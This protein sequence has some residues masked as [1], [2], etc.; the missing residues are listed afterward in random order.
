MNA[1]DFAQKIMEVEITI[2][3]LRREVEGWRQHTGSAEHFILLEIDRL[4]VI[5]NDLK[6]TIK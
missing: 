4:I 6:G 5:L 2:N 3:G 1:E